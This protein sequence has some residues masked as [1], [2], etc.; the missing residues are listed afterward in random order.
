MGGKA[1]EGR[2]RI[3][4]NVKELERGRAGFVSQFGCARFLFYLDTYMIL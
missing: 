2:E 3:S 4:T 1:R